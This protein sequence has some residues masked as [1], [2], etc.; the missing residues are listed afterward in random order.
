MASRVPKVDPHVP[1]L[2]ELLSV[3]AGH[4]LACCSKRLRLF[5]IASPPQSPSKFQGGNGWLRCSPV[6]WLSQRVVFWRLLGISTQQHSR[7]RSKLLTSET[8]PG[9]IWSKT[10]AVGRVVSCRVLKCVKSKW[11]KTIA[12]SDCSVWSLGKGCK[13]CKSDV[14]TFSFACTEKLLESQLRTT[15]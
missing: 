12:R 7:W 13:G 5:V 11:I 15:S 6:I 14:D 1:S 10:G 9:E 3:A 8:T 4:P 2:D